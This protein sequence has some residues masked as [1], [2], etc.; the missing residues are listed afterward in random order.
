[1]LLLEE[2]QSNGVQGSNISVTLSQMIP[3]KSLLVQFEG[4]AVL[5][6][7]VL[8]QAHATQGC[9]NVDVIR[10]RNADL[11]HMNLTVLP[12]GWTPSSGIISSPYDSRLQQCRCD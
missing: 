10:T 4:G 7:L 8:Y 3:V 11:R 9:S 5:F 6:H 2:D 1:M 12:D